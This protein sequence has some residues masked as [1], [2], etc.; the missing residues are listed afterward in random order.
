MEE[1]LYDGFVATAYAIAFA[2]IM[3]LVLHTVLRAKLAKRAFEIATYDRTAVHTNNN[4][5]DD[6]E[7]KA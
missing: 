5:Q 4:P 3:W 2:L 1:V 6:N 7:T